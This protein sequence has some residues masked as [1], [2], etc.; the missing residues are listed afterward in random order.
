MYAERVSPSFFVSS[1]WLLRAVMLNRF[2]FLAKSTFTR[3]ATGPFI[4]A[5]SFASVSRQPPDS[6]RFRAESGKFSRLRVTS[7]LAAFEQRPVSP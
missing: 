3:K 6:R 4:V 1:L 5:G 7:K 2:A